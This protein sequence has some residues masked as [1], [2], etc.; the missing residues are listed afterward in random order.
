MA[1]G[2]DGFTNVRLQSG[3]NSMPHES[4]HFM[5]KSIFPMNDLN[6][7]GS[8]VNKLSSINGSLPTVDGMEF[9]C[10]SVYDE[11]RKVTAAAA[12]SAGDT[13]TTTTTTFT[14]STFWKVLKAGS[15]ISFPGY[16]TVR[17][18]ADPTSGTVS[19]YNPSVAIPAGA[20]G[21]H[22]GINPI[23]QYARPTGVTRA[24]NYHVEYLEGIQRVLRSIS[25]V[26]ART[27]TYPEDRV[28][29]DQRLQEAANGEFVRDISHR[30]L[31]SEAASGATT[32][33]YKTDG[34]WTRGMKYHRVDVNGVLT[35]DLFNRVC[36]EMQRLTGTPSIAM[37]H[38]YDMQ[39]RLS[40][41]AKNSDIYRSFG[42][43]EAWG[44]KAAKLSNCHGIPVSMALVDAIFDDAPSLVKKSIVLW[45]PKAIRLKELG[46]GQYIQRD[47]QDNG[48][49]LMQNQVT[50][51]IGVGDAS[52][53]AGVFVLSGVDSLEAAV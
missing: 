46:G 52:D 5:E 1:I 22:G 10:Y 30:I 20:E 19:I 28:V 47:T 33:Y 16:C 25:V 12:I 11:P 44:T 42:N 3:S 18:S 4:I 38:G 15:M 37:A 24:P 32:G 14:P 9:R 27:A 45:S 41:W 48:T 29:E 26:A 35:Y 53:Y 13:T 36:R 2:Y 39:G 50:R 17:V 7:V 23:E 49:G 40:T 34:L 8:F 31:F 6:Q 21:M 43:D 51:W